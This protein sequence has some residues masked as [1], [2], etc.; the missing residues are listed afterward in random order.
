M[1]SDQDQAD[2]FELVQNYLRN[3]FKK[4]PRGMFARIVGEA[5]EYDYRIV[6]TEKYCQQQY[7]NST[8]LIWVSVADSYLDQVRLP[9][10]RSWGL[11]ALHNKECLHLSSR[12]PENFS[13]VLAREKS[14][15]SIPAEAIATLFC[16]AVLTSK[17]LSYTLLDDLESI[18]NIKTAPLDQREFDKLSSCFQQVSRLPHGDRITF[19]FT[20]IGVGFNDSRAQLI[21]LEIDYSLSFSYTAKFLSENLFLMNLAYRR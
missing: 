17:S 1:T 4:P 11:F 21:T 7:F 3:H 16:D 14:I 19:E 10:P 2:S 8:Q 20:V 5:R 12:T 13:K 15:A 18:E 9:A 6:E